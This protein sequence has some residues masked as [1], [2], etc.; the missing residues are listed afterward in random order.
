MTFYSVDYFQKRKKELED[1][2]NVI[3]P[4]LQELSDYFLPRSTQFIARNTRKPIVKN[5]KIIDSL[6]IVG[7][8]EKILL[9]DIVTLSSSEKE[10]IQ[11]S[12]SLLSNPEVIIITNQ[13]LKF[14][15]PRQSLV[16]MFQNELYL[17]SN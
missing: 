11:I 8:D 15:K 10:L 4:D 12:V 17:Y 5:K 16:I 6:R 14:Y 13:F 1:V 2:F 3:K 7:L 9:R